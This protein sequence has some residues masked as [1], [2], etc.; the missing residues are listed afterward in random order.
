MLPSDCAV[1]DNIF[2]STEK[3]AG[4]FDSHWDSESKSFDPESFNPEATK[5]V[6][7]KCSCIVVKGS[8]I[9]V[10]GSSIMVKG[11]SIMVKGL[12]AKSFT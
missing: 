12:Q 1:N 2:K 6:T 8:S 9:M 7:S 5:Y 10:K 4:E 11:S 3:R